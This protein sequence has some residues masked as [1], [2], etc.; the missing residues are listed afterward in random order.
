MVKIC[1]KIFSEQLLDK[2]RAKISSEPDLSRRALSRFLCQ[3][4]DWK[5]RNGA[6]QELA[7]RRALLG[8]HRR[9][10]VKLPKGAPAPAKKLVRTVVHEPLRVS[11]QFKELGPLRLI[12]VS[13]NEPKLS[14][15]WNTLIDKYHPLGYQPMAGAQQRY[16]IESKQGWVGAIGL[17][18]AAWSLQDR[19]QYI[20]W[21]REA[22]KRNL[23]QIVCNWRFLILP[24]VKVPGLAS[25]I[26]SECA[27]RLPKDWQER[28]GYRPVLLET[29]VETGVHRGTCY[30]GAN[31]QHVGKTR[32]RGR[33]DRE[34][35]CASPC[36]DIYVYPLVKDWKKQ[37][38]LAPEPEP[39]AV[40]PRH[41]PAQDWTEEEF[42]M[43]SLPDRRLNQRLRTIAADF[44][45]QPEANIPQASGSRAKTKA[46]YRF[47]DHKQ[48]R[49]EKIMSPHRE[50]TLQRMAGEKV[51]LAV[52]DSTALT[53]GDRPGTEG[54]GPT[55]NDHH[56]K[57]GFWLH[58]TMAYNL[59]GLALGLLDVQVWARESTELRP[60]SKRGS[61]AVEEKESRKW[62]QSFQQTISAQSRLPNTQVVSVGDREADLYELFVLARDKGANTKLLIRV[63]HKNRR[64][65]EEQDDL[66]KH[67]QNQK[68]AG[69][70]PVQI[71]RRGNQP[72]R[73]AQLQIRFCPVR[74]QPP[75]G[76]QS[77][78]IVEAWAVLAIEPKAPPGIKPI[79]WML[80]TTVP[81]ENLEQA[82]QKLHWY[83]IRSL[84]EG[85]HRTIKSGCRVEKRQLL[86]AEGLKNCLALDLVVGWRIV[87]M[88]RLGRE[89]PDLPCTKVFEVEEWKALHLFVNRTLKVPAKPPPLQQTIRMVASLGGFLGRKGDGQPG[90]QT[91]WLG[92][93]RLKDIVA[94]INLVRR[95]QQTRAP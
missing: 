6:Y 3:W 46:A 92:L 14:V 65:A 30:R 78:G 15:L 11:C 89:Q 8:L 20:G 68:A 56:T 61:L 44:L 73:T 86:N 43:A 90:T 69:L 80:L 91:I 34:H 64:M 1:G 19:D 74:L 29:F 47:F 83:A 59:E 95:L 66:L 27:R 87:Y 31:W 81:V 42:G 71:G 33:N 67:I 85:F 49:M 25:R 79:Q 41:Q 7:A 76:K 26:L 35:Q 93:R 32:G 40:T 37:L 21:S 9:K 24:T 63:Q 16:L 12:A 18:A 10:L 4:L 28:Y 5:G 60:G 54:L 62:L 55:N 94:A 84:I 77:L 53:Y 51:V 70:V 39:I 17:G 52:Q 58:S 2:L 82:S 88:S 13:S 57:V 75:K 50:A 72:A 38:C 23:H 36:K 45:A 22:R 48:L